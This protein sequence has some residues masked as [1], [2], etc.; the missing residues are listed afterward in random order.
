MDRSLL[1]RDDLALRPGRG[2]RNP[3]LREALAAEGDPTAA[4][5]LT[6]DLDCD[7]A[8]VGG[9]YTGLWTAYQLTERA[10]DLRVVVLE[11]DICGGGRERVG[12]R[13]R[14]VVPPAPGRRPFPTRRD[15]DGIDD[16][17]A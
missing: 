5:P 3:W 4:P 12:A 15:A 10:P 1:T 17:A 13:D 7:V 6:G 2:L 16:A 14:D 9:G 8:I 11:R